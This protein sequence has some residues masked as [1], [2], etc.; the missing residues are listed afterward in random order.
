MAECQLP[1]LNTRV[2]FPSPAPYKNTP[3][4]LKNHGF[5]GFFMF[6]EFLCKSLFWYSFGVI[7]DVKRDVTNHA[8]PANTIAI[9]STRVILS[10]GLDPSEIPAAMALFT[11]SFCHFSVG[12]FSACSFW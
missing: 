10:K 4:A 6:Y 3:E 12:S 2:R 5:R 7:G 11:V 8:F 1:K 9:P